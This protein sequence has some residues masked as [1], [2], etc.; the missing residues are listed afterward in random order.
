MLHVF[1][2]NLYDLGFLSIGDSKVR[3][4]SS[5]SSEFEDSSSSSESEDSSSEEDIH[6]SSPRCVVSTDAMRHDRDEE[7]DQILD[8]CTEDNTRDANHATS[9]SA[10]NSRQHRV[11]SRKHRRLRQ[12]P[13]TVLK[14][15]ICRKVT[16]DDRRCPRNGRTLPAPQM[17]QEQATSIRSH[18]F[19]TSDA[20]IAAL[21]AP[22]VGSV[23]SSLDVQTWVASSLAYLK[24]PESVELGGG[25]VEEMVA[26]CRL[27][28][29]QATGSSLVAIITYMQL[30]IQCQRY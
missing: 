17:W 12:H 9:A 7:M 27:L 18:S 2:A 16:L 22:R 11:T 15:S 21:A 20:L 23:A 13:Y 24:V 6:T 3:V 30:A 25:S 28:S 8:S 4:F 1:P 26:R 29:V 5:S 10:S 14:D 19:I